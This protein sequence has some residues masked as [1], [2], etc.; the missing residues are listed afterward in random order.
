MSPGVAFED[1][2]GSLAGLSVYAGPASAEARAPYE[3]AAT[4]LRSLGEI[5][6]SNLVELIRSRP[7]FVPIL[8]SV[9]GLSQEQLKNLLRH[10][11]GTSGWIVLGR[12]NPESIVSLLDEDEFGLVG[13]L[14]LELDQSWSYGHVLF[15]RSTSRRRAGR[16]ISSGRRL[17]DA[18]EAVVRKLSLPYQLRTEFIGVGDRRVPCDVAIPRNMEGTL[19]ACAVKGF[20]S[21]G[22]KLT[23]AVREVESMA[24]FRHAHQFVYA[25]I[26][27]IG[28]LGRRADL[29]RIYDLQV[30]GHLNGVYNVASFGQFEVDLAQAAKIHRLL[31]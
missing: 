1:L 10:R 18:V 22:S 20:D 17:E 11:L 25:V 3:E 26:D 21:T 28:W 13:R 6:Q 23:D 2:L 7:D 27:G 15:E 4:V 31:P 29:K 12:K 5:G 19:I 8:A 24:A 30:S 16:A 14:T 9:V